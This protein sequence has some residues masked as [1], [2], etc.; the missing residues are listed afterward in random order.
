MV[1][2]VRCC[3]IVAYTAVY[4]RVIILMTR[5]LW[6]QVLSTRQNFRSSYEIIKCRCCCSRAAALGS[7]PPIIYA[8]F[9]RSPSNRKTIRRAQTGP[10]HKRWCCCRRGSREIACLTSV[11][12]LMAY[13][14]TSFLR[15]R[16]VS[17]THLTLPTILLV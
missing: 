10:P 6:L 1:L 15:A 13:L 2:S 14:G 16:S 9:S 11:P 8:S 7:P 3:C 4:Y 17:Y 12:P 5:Q